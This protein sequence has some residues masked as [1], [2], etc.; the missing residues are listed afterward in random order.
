MASGIIQVKRQ[1]GI[2]VGAAALGAL[3]HADVEHALGGADP[4]SDGIAAGA[5][6]DIPTSPSAPAAHALHAAARH[7]LAHGITTI[8][9]VGAAICAL[10]AIAVIALAAH[11]R[12]RA[13]HPLPATA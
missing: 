6:R 1:I 3:F 4:I 11:A 13:P 9:L 2:A 7:A 5:T 8:A 12:R 10:A